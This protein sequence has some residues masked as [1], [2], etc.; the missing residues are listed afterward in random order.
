MTPRK[1]QKVIKQAEGKYHRIAEILNRENKNGR[2]INVYWVYQYIKN[3]KE[4]GN[5]EIRQRMYLP[6]KQ[7]KPRTRKAIVDNAP[8]WIIWWRTLTKEQR[9]QIIRQAWIQL[10]TLNK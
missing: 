1:L 4:P 7:S 6:A 2:T 8:Y 3:G 5:P 10:C 9:H